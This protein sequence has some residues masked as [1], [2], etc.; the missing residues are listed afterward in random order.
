MYNLGGWL[1]LVFILY[2]VYTNLNNNNNIIINKVVAGDGK[3][4]AV[5][6]WLCVLAGKLWL[7]VGSGGCWQ[8]NYGW[9]WVAVDGHTI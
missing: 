5:H 8:Q 1:L 9:S 4:M 7:V 3:I 6:R 2:I